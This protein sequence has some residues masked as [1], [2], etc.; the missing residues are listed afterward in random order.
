MLAATVG[1]PFQVDL[2]TQNKNRPIYVRVQVEL[3]LLGVFPK[4]TNVGISM[5]NGEVKEKW[6]NIKYEYVP[7]YCKTCKL[8]GHNKRSITF[9]ILS[10]IK[11][12]RGMMTINKGP[13]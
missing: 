3:D 8:Q 9:H 11:R 13:R 1:K 7:K 5:K 2:A 4:R 6:I 10:Y 12:K